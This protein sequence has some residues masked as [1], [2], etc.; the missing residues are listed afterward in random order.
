[1]IR[2]ENKIVFGRKNCS[3]SYNPDHA[4]K[5]CGRIKCEKCKGTGRTKGG[6]GK[7]QCRSCY[8]GVVTSWEPEHLRVCPSCKGQWENAEVENDCD[9]MPQS[10]WEGLEFRVIRHN[11]EMSG[12]EQLLAIGCVFSC[13]DYGRSKGKTDAEMIAEVKQH[14]HV[15]A[16][17]VCDK[18][19]NLCQ[20]VGIFMT[21]GGYSVRA[22]FDEVR[23]IVTIALETGM[24]EYMQRGAEMAANGQNGTLGAVYKDM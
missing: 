13:N 21:N 15:Q 14:S 1:M 7:G 2:V 5:A 16:C 10:I 9:S 8:G 19:G 23:T 6:T 3:C 12:N 18:D 20:Y 4:G 17:K 11:R 22:V 24:Q